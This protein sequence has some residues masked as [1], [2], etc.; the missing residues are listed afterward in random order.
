MRFVYIL[1]AAAPRK[2]RQYEYTVCVCGPALIE[3]FEEETNGQHLDIREA[4]SA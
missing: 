4:V 2:Q 1:F 3:I